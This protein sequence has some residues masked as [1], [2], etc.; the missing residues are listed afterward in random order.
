MQKKID[1]FISIVLILAIVLTMSIIFGNS[2]KS[3]AESGEQS[4]KVVEIVRPVIDPNHQMSDQ[5]ISFVVRKSAHFIEFFVLGLECALLAYHISRKLTLAGCVCSL[6]WCL[7]SANTDEFIQSFTGRG[8]KVSDVLID[9]SG[10][11]TCVALGFAL[12]RAIKF[13]KRK[14][15]KSK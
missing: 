14:I 1:V 6:L 9:F 10:A 3:T 11:L 8:S 13:L 4:D 12:G 2:L 15:Q 7:L 5:E